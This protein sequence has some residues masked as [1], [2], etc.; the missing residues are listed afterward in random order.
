MHEWDHDD[1]RRLRALLRRL[2]EIARQQECSPS[3]GFRIVVRNRGI[4]VLPLDGI[5]K[6]NPVIRPNTEI[7]SVGICTSSF[8]AYAAARPLCVFRPLP[9][10]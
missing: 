10:M 3:R 2:M 8:L 4:T 1:I 9:T 5:G 6:E 7:A